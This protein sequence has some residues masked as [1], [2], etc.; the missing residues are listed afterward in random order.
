GGLYALLVGPTLIL[1]TI[2]DALANPW[3]SVGYQSALHATDLLALLGPGPANPGYLACA[4]AILGLVVA[5]G[6]V[7]GTRE[8]A[9]LVPLAALVFWVMALGPFLVAGGP[10]TDIPL[11][12]SLLQNLPVFSIG[13]D[14]ARYTLV[15]RLGVGVLAAFGLRAILDFMRKSG[16]T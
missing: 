8:I 3:L 10:T 6:A 4:V 11:P 1:P 5:W 13:R 14:P 9:L 12:Y 16:A 2:Q 7:G 15:G